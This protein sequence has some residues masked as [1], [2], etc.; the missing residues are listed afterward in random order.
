MGWEHTAR[1]KR[2]APVGEYEPETYKVKVYDTF[3]QRRLLAAALMIRN[4]MGIPEFFLFAADYVIWHHRRLP[5]VRKAYR[6]AARRIV[7]DGRTRE[8]TAR[9][10]DEAWS[11]CVREM[12]KREEAAR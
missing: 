4:G 10:L 6:Q 12:R 11:T 3:D 2:L 9:H 5:V 1:E 7:A 8:A